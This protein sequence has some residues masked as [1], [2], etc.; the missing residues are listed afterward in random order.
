MKSILITV[1]VLIGSINLI[2]AQNKPWRG[3][4]GFTLGTNQYNGELGN[5]FYRLS[6]IN[7]LFGLNYEHYVSRR[8]NIEGRLWMGNWGYDLTDSTRFGAN[9]F[10]TQLIGKVKLRNSD[11]PI[12]MPYA[13]GGVGLHLMSNWSLEDNDGNPMYNA[14]N[15][16]ALNSNDF[17]RWIG[18][19]PV[20]LGVQFKL[21]DRVF[22]NV[23][24]TFTMTG[25]KGWDGI[26]NNSTDQMLTHSIGIAFGLFGWN[27]TDH[28]GVGDKMDK[29][30]GTP[31]IA[32]VD[33]A[34]CPIDT[35]LDGI[36]DFEDVC[37]QSVGT[38]AAKGCPDADGDSFADQVDEC[39]TKAGLAQFNGCPD[40]DGDGFTDA[41]DNCPTIKGEPKFFG[42]PDTDMDGVA[43]IDDKCANTPK[44]AQVDRNGCPLDTDKDGVADYQDKCPND[45]GI[46]A[47]KGCPEVKEEVKA[48]FRQ[49]LR[50]VKFE[51]GKDVIKP[52]SFGILDEVVKVMKDNPS[53]KLKID[54]HTDNV[55]DAVKNLELSD[56]RA[57]AVKK[58]LVDHG[59]VA[60]SIIRA[61]GYGDTAPVADNATKAGKAQN[62]RVEFLVEF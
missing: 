56:R 15:G 37:P 22:L 32:K 35:D 11:D 3:A 8:F 14:T 19:L 47:N 57:K 16:D 25:E 31:S 21:S 55:G 1:S 53:Y 41:Q 59:V 18:V 13:F 43:D 44:S 38:I 5:D 54:G 34:G 26:V 24:E 60:E 61:Q 4:M 42:C 6:Q 27:D 40:T 62:R 9:V 20:G 58:Y 10:T 29:C 50:G 28:D 12:W 45:A 46:Q 7:P 2:V 36:A 39:P 33:A 48:L 23:D 52:E 17:N 49:A 30:P 51:T